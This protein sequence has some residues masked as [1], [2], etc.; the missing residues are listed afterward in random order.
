MDEFNPNYYLEL[1]G[2]LKR[3]LLAKFMR[4]EI[5]REDFSHGIYEVDLM[6]MTNKEILKKWEKLK[7]NC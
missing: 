3:E 6:T 4:G 7:E 2:K 5:T 1:P